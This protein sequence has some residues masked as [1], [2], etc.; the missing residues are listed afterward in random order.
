MKIKNFFEKYT[1]F[2]WIQA[3]VLVA[4]LWGLALL[5]G[6]SFESVDRTSVLTLNADSS[7]AAPSLTEDE[8][9]DALDDL[10]A[11]ESGAFGNWD[12]F[13]DLPEYS[14]P[15]Y[16]PSSRPSVSSE[17][18]REP[19][20][21]PE[22][23]AAPPAES[24]AETSQPTGPMDASSI[25]AGPESSAPESSQPS[26]PAE[27][28]SGEP[29]HPSDGQSSVTSGGQSP[30][31]AVNLGSDITDDGPTPTQPDA[32]SQTQ[33]SSPADAASAASSPDGAQG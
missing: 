27:P 26:A 14:E 22:S 24:S 32:S 5:T 17:P 12:E 3:L 33:P 11:D 25:P 4:A 31:D 18:Q 15:S 9:S 19:S 8:K 20:S 6:A 10:F 21:E 23:S 28:S 29:S 1:H 7:E 30:G 13:S 2:L 16:R